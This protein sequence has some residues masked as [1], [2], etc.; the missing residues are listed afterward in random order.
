[1]SQVNRTSTLNK[2]LRGA[3]LFAVQNK[4]SEENTLM[5]QGKNKIIVKCNMLGTR[6]LGIFFNNYSQPIL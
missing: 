1:M 6:K 2:L 3:D 5:T 4:S